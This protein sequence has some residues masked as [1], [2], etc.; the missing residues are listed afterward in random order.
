MRLTPNS[1]ARASCLI[2]SPPEYL[3]STM[4]RRNSSAN[5]PVTVCRLIMACA[6]SLRPSRYRV[7]SLRLA[8][9]TAIPAVRQRAVRDNYRLIAKNHLRLRTL[10]SCFAMFIVSN[11]QVAV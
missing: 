7:D 11:V 8:H 5:Q 2:C 3:P 10:T 1:D 4:R 9:A 6:F